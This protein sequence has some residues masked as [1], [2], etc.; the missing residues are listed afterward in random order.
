MPPSFNLS[1]TLFKQS[2]RV[3]PLRSLHIQHEVISHHRS[4]RVLLNTQWQRH[5]STQAPKETN[6]DTLQKKVSELSEEKKKLEKEYE[7]LQLPVSIPGTPGGQGGTGGGGLFSLTGQPLFDAALTTVIGL[8]IVFMGGIAYLEWY[9]WN[10]LNKIEKAFEPGYDP[11]LEIASH[12]NASSVPGV[13]EEHLRRKEQDLVDRIISG[14]EKGHYYLL[15]GQKGAGKTTMVYDAMVKCNADGVSIC[16]AH[17]DLE[18]FRLRLGKTL[19]FE[20]N[21]DSQTGLFQ[22]RDPREGGPGLDIERALNKLEKVALRRARKT[23]RPL[24]L[25]FNNVHF[26]Q[27]TDEGRNILLQ[28]QQRA[29]SWAESRIATLVFSSDDFWPFLELRKSASRML[30]LSIYDLEKNEAMMAARRLRRNFLHSYKRDIKTLEDRETFDEAISIIGG[31]LSALSKLAK[32]DD[33]VKAAHEMVSREKGW[34]L[35]QIGLIEDHDDDVMDEQKWSSCSW[36]LLRKFVQLYKEHEEK[37]ANGEEDPGKFY[38]P[39]VSFEEARQLMTRTDF[40]ED[41]DKN[42]IVAIDVNFNVHPDSMII[43]QAAKEVVERDGFDEMLDN[44]RDRVDEIESLHRTRELTFK[45]VSKGDRIRLSDLFMGRHP[46][47]NM[48]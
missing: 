23:G 15:L 27:H 46:L 47:A 26:F 35:S 24:V 18:V 25:V 17:P 45:D 37:V 20:F 14:Q 28:L 4:G 33:M 12:A 29:E 42:N 16:D 38:L 44:V 11:A 8:G 3:R 7:M 21:E 41:L 13:D 2:V 36:L 31:R 9:K 6:E 19:N 48:F 22:R 43:L 1:S 30:T 40:I 5:Q 34:L 32:M 39:S 10:V